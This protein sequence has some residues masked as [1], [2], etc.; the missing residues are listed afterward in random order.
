MKRLLLLAAMAVPASAQ[1]ASPPWHGVWQG[2]IGTLPVRACLQQRSEDYSNGSYYYLSR[3]KPIA[4][5]HE[6]DGSWAE[7]ADGGAATGKWAVAGVTGGRLTGTWRSGSKALPIALTR[8]AVPAGEED[9]CGAAAF[10]APRLKPVQVR[11][12]P[13]RKDG[14]AYIELT[15]DVGSN[16]SDIVISSFSFPPTRPGDAAINAALRL[17][18]AKPG[19]D[20]DYAE[21]MRMSLASLGRDGDFTFSY[22]PALVT[23]EFLSVEANSGGFCG[24]AHPDESTTHV[25]FDRA[26]GRR[27]DLTRWFTPRGV[28]PDEGE[29]GAS[30]HRLTPALRALV[31]RH[32]PFGKGEDADCKEA[33][34]GED[35]WDIALDRRGIAFAPSLPH[36]AQACEDS[37]VV[38]F[39]EL[40]AFL[41]PAG[42]AGAAR[43]KP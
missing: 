9:P 41:S 31:L 30:I 40:A 2:T 43:V 25:I 7:E 15:Y 29:E 21:C 23:S 13:A 39:A 19:S 8:V 11:S 24:G 35:Y 5:S 38:P 37:A 12:K 27:I 36:V 34:S 3:M 16:F 14:F 33:V 32:Y 42:K 6:D 22:T 17:D 20:A 26:T 10:I 18:P 1:A 4:L 28:L